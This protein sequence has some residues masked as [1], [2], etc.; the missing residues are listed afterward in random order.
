[1]ACESRL[2][3]EGGLIKNKTEIIAGSRVVTSYYA[4]SFQNCIALDVRKEFI[5]MN[6]SQTGGHCQASLLRVEKKKKIHEQM[7]LVT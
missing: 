5:S 1:M 2:G 7:S 4:L 3:V 6:S